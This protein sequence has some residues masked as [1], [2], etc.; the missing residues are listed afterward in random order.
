MMP[1]GAM[2]L[3]TVLATTAVAGTK[4]VGQGR[5]TR[6]L[7]NPA[8]PEFEPVLQEIGAQM[9]ELEAAAAA[10]VKIPARAIE[11]GPRARMYKCWRLRLT[12]D[13]G[14]KAARVFERLHSVQAALRDQKSKLTKDL[15]LY[16][17]AVNPTADQR[18]RIQARHRSLSSLL[19]SYNQLIALGLKSKLLKISESGFFSDR[20]MI[21]PLLKENDYTMVYD[22]GAPDCSR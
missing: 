1:S 16:S 4:P 9:P 19:E 18:E 22:D 7:T 10:A 17:A 6:T 5:S 11:L 14:K 8:D 15:L 20:Q 3:I 2:V 13:H 21:I 12:G